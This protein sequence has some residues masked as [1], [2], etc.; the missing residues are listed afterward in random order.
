MLFH[1]FSPFFLSE[2][3]S[4]F[5][6][7]GLVVRDNGEREAETALLRHMPYAS[8]TE[9]A[10]KEGRVVQTLCV[11]TLNLFRIQQSLQ[12]MTVFTIAVVRPPLVT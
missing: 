3:H 6:K 10:S 4:V 9:R 5:E 8:V 12:N 2:V 7:G 1:Y 11:H